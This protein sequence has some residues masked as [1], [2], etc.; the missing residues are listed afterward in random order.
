LEE[1]MKAATL[2][3]VVCMG[4]AVV[5][6]QPASS[7]PPEQPKPGKDAAPDTAVAT[8]DVL[9]EDVAAPAD[10]A[11]GPEVARKDVAATPDT[12][13]GKDTA[14]STKPDTATPDPVPDATVLAADT[15]ARD[16]A[17]ATTD[18]A[19][20]RD[21]TAVAPDMASFCTGGASRMVLNGVSSTPAVTGHVLA[22]DCCDGGE[23]DVSTPSLPQTIVVRWQAQEGSFSGFKTIDLANPPS[24]WGVHVGTTCPASSSGCVDPADSYTTGLTGSLVLAMGKS[25]RYDMSLCLHVEESAS[26]PHPLIHTLDLFAT[27][28]D[29]D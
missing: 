1:D 8:P 23:F 6:C 7:P 25:A 16:T 28:I 5:G 26:S 15:S 24:G 29:A 10:A 3:S 9:L 20:A 4:F 13:P 19:T 14:V 22:L 21:T 18:L 2:L 17:P 12:A 27:H 11:A